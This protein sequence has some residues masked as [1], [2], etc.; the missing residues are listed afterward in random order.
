VS[1]RLR[2]F[3]ELGVLDTTANDAGGSHA[4]RLSPEGEAFFPVVV[5]ILMWGERWF[6]ASGGPAVVATHRACDNPF[7]PELACSACHGGITRR[8]LRIDTGH[9]DTGHTEVAATSHA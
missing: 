5:S 7:L 4:Y 8:G 2:T 3:V 6:P 9:I 1:D